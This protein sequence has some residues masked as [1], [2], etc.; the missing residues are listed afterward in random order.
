MPLSDDTLMEQGRP[1]LGPG[2]GEV[3][4][5]QPQDAPG[6]R[7]AAGWV[8]ADA[9]VDGHGAGGWSRIDDAGDDGMALWGQT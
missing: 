6:S 9:Y 2:P 7:D 1:P 3:D 4:R 5:P 8:K